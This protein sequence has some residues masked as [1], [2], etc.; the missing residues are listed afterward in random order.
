MRLGLYGNFVGSRC[1][2]WVHF[3]FTTLKDIDKA[4]IKVIFVLEFA[5]CKRLTILI[6]TNFFLSTLYVGAGTYR[7][8]VLSSR[9][10]FCMLCRCY[11]LSYIIC[12][13][14]C[15]NTY[16]YAVLKGRFLKNYWQLFLPM[17]DSSMSCGTRN[18]E[19]DSMKL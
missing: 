11:A 1:C 7:C 9:L 8:F 4:E 16:M 18:C 13:Y 17:N 15:C 14:C 19:A 3:H 5:T 10:V 6:I 2:I 12:M